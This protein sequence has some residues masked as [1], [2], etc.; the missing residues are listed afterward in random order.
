[1][2]WSQREERTQMINI[3]AMIGM[4]VIVCFLMLIAVAGCL[5]LFGAICKSVSWI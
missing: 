2:D 4:F 3:L 5:I 1:M